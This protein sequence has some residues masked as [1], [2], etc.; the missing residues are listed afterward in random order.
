MQFFIGMV[1]GSVIAA[2]VALMGTILFLLN[3][4]QAAMLVGC[5]MAAF[6]TFLILRSQY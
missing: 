6:C 1:A 5:V 4:M 3:D 2:F